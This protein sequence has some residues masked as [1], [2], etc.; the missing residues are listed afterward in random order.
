MSV[1]VGVCVRLREGSVVIGRV[2]VCLL[3]VVGVVLVCVFLRVWVR[4]FG[5]SSGLIGM[6]PNEVGDECV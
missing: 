1:S 3:C 6:F 4:G 2:G 5:C